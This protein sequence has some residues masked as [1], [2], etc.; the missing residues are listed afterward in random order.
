ML[1]HLHRVEL[2]AAWHLKVF[3]REIRLEAIV[4]ALG[5]L[6]ADVAAGVW[7]APAYDLADVYDHAEAIATRHAATLGVRTLDIL[8]V[9]AAACL[10]TT[11]F[12]TGDT[13]QANLAEAAGMR[14]TRLR[15]SR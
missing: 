12:V 9:A 14:V 15:A 8:H 11:A 7:E 3:R 1:T 10:G 13:R 6:A 4:H 2:A 5:D